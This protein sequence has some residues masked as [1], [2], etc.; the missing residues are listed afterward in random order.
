MNDFSNGASCSEPTFASGGGKRGRGN[1]ADDA[2]QSR[3][4]ARRDRDNN[5]AGPTRQQPSMESFQASNTK[6]YRRH[7]SDAQKLPA[8]VLRKAPT[9]NHYKLDQI[10]RCLYMGNKEDAMG[11]SALKERGV[12]HVVNATDSLPNYHGSK[13]E[14]HQVP[15]K[16]A[17][18]EAIGRHFDA[19]VR[20]IDRAIN[21]SGGICLVHCV[22]G[23]SRSAA[24]VIAFLMYSEK[25]LLKDAFDY[26]KKRRSSV[27]PNN[28]FMFQLA[29]YEL[30]LHQGSS[31]CSAPAWNFYEWNE[32]KKAI[33]PSQR[34]KPGLS[35]HRSSSASEDG[36][37]GICCVIS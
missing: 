37:G 26:A 10:L 12:T 1:V 30:Q 3:S 17:P 4:A 7:I 31:V 33:P 16:D 24:I 18:D 6:S 34:L 35:S 9:H 5:Q 25:L 15:V 14:Y 32:R 21:D 29:E 2:V 27:Q 36:A 23:C 11:Y 28:G 13:L 22:A 20:F 19:A 8:S